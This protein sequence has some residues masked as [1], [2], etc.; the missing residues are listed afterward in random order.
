MTCLLVVIELVR[1]SRTTYL[2]YFGRVLVGRQSAAQLPKES[3]ITCPLANCCNMASFKLARVHYK[4]EGAAY[5][6]RLWLPKKPELQSLKVI[7]ALLA[8]LSN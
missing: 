5:Q 8:S 1:D 2:V 4:E 6:R 3:L 7:C